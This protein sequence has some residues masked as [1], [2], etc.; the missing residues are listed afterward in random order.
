MSN[1]LPSAPQ[2]P[3]KLL[4]QV[5]QTIRLRGL[6]YQ[7]EKAY[8]DWAKRYILYHQKRH[9][10]EMGAAEVRAFLTHLVLDR[11]V[12]PSTQNQALHALLFLYYQVLEIELPYIGPVG[13]EKKQGESPPRAVLTREEV[14]ALLSHLS[15]T[16]WLMA[17][18]LYGSGLRLIECLRLRVKDIDFG[19]NL[20]LVY[21]GKGFKDRVTMLPERLKEPLREHLTRV[22]EAHEIDLREGF[23]TV[24]LPYALARKYPQA[25]REF[26]W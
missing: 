16:K 7:T 22:K 8:V 21:E 10:Q 13:R 23:G 1:N 14:A 20:I 26:K 17:S 12:S 24:E 11:N 15:G 19:N 9:P 25:E 5:R 2:Q 4:D 6:S 3:P 18:L